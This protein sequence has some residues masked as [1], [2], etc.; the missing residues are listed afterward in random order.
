MPKRGASHWLG[1]LPGRQ[2]HLG[3]TLFLGGPTAMCCLLSTREA[4][5]IL[6]MAQ[7]MMFLLLFLCCLCFLLLECALLF[8]SWGKWL[9]GVPHQSGQPTTWLL[10]LLLDTQTHL[11]STAFSGQ[12]TAMHCRLLIREAR[13][14]VLVAKEVP[15]LWVLGHCSAVSHPEVGIYTPGCSAS[16]SFQACV[17]SKGLALEASCRRPCFYRARTKGSELAGDGMKPLWRWSMGVVIDGGSGRGRSVAW[18]VPKCG[19]RRRVVWSESPFPG[20]RSHLPCYLPERKAAPQAQGPLST[21]SH[22]P[23]VPAPPR[24]IPGIPQQDGGKKVPGGS[25]VL[26]ETHQTDTLQATQPFALGS[27]S[28][29]AKYPD[30]LLAG[31]GGPV[32]L[33]SVS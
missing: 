27:S 4:R 9:C 25:G 1:L 10:Q 7:G 29:W 18:K 8:Y 2:T 33:H 6:V 12:P 24:P 16:F 21:S 30:I 20:A 19:R 23:W 32:R 26:R 17:A 13:S 11:C 14:V 5:L 28:E 3:S 22:G 15:L 31:K